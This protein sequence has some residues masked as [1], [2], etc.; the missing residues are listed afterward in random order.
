MILQS[1]ADKTAEIRI[2]PGALLYFLTYET[3]ITFTL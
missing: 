2:Y 1:I 3:C